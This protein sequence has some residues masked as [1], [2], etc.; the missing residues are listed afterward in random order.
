MTMDQ[1]ATPQP[2]TTDTLQPTK[3]LNHLRQD[4][5]KIG[6]WAV[7]AT[8]ILAYLYTSTF[9]DNQP[10]FFLPLAMGLMGLV[11]LLH[12]RWGRLV[13]EI[14]E[15]KS[16]F[17]EVKLFAGLTLLQ[18]LALSLWGFHSQLEMAQYL[19]L[20]AS[21]ILYVA[22]R[23]NRLIQG[24]LGILF[25]S[26][27]LYNT[28]Y[29]PF[30]HFLLSF[31]VLSTA[32]PK[33]AGKTPAETKQET[34]TIGRFILTLLVTLVLIA[35]VISQLGQVSQAFADSIGQ[36]FTWLGNL[37]NLLTQLLDNLFA[38]PRLLLALPISLWLFGL[39]G[40]SLIERQPRR[41]TYDNFLHRI[42]RHQTFPS[43]TTYIIAG[44]LCLIYALFVVI[45]LGEVTSVQG[46]SA[47]DAS[48][49]A[50]SGFWQLVR[51]SLL[52]FSVLAGL[53]L[54]TKPTVFF[55]KASRLVLT[56]LFGF[57]T[58]FALLAGW[59]LFGIYI[60]LYGLTPLR[61][62]SGWFVLVLL[63]WCV[64]VLIRLHK[65][66]QAIRWGLSYAFTSFTSLPFL[67]TL[68]M[69]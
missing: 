65:P 17:L 62:L 21:F 37:G 2:I 23:N 1:T 50:V 30:K 6:K 22:A 31:D 32:S 39:I 58:L 52:N 44:S 33:A 42:S 4:Q 40:G 9:L 11:E 18:A 27:G 51:V 29:L 5:L 41:L 25:W 13:G 61:L 3:G 8:L 10:I 36:L 60:F 16:S 47:P 24:R 46:I 38:S 57:A 63:V 28:L 59:K 53:Y 54:V 45:G 34:G 55:N 19:I 14:A 66:I 49:M 64:L 69:R 56:A 67:Y 12:K 15:P 48:N 68:F 7:L 43:W 35:F 20:H 26:D